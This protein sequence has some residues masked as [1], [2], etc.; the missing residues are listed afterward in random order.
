MTP[1]EDIAHLGSLNETG[2]VLGRKFVWKTLDSDE[3]ASA[4]AASS[5]FRDEKTKERILKIEK[6]ARAITTIEGAPFSVSPDESARGMTPMLKARELL[7]KWQGPVVDKVYAEYE[8]L[9]K[10]RD[11]VILELE[12]NAISPIT[13]SGAGK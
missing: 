4:H 3:E 5:I 2:T 8:K 1:A 10:K 12:K 6:L 13:S 11:Q 9:E 7:Y